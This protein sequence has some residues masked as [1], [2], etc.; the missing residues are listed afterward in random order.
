MRARVVIAAALTLAIA[1]CAS[2]PNGPRKLKPVANPSAVVATELAFAR[3]AQE[4][5]QW[6]AF[7]KYA[8][9]SAIMLLESGPVNARSWLAGKTDPAQAVSWEPL[10]IWSSCDGSLAVSK[11][12]FTS[13]D[14]SPGGEGYTVWKRDRP[15]RYRYLFDM[16][17]AAPR[18]EAPEMI[19]ADVAECKAAP[20]APA[21]GVAGQSDDGSLAWSYSFENGVRGFRVWTSGKAGPKLVIDQSVPAGDDTARTGN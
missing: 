3:A 11:F 7:R 15:D 1:G 5:G 18:A 16:G 2:G 13:A 17:F 20:A 14:G 10:A 4:E 12:A 9:K 6:K 19:Q 21:S 8:D